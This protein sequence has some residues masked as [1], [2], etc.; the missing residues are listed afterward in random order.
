MRLKA[1][2][3]ERA[4]DEQVHILR[5]KQILVAVEPGG[6]GFYLR[7]EVT[8]LLEYLLGFQ[9]YTRLLSNVG[10]LLMALSRL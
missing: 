2:G 1:P 5:I 6:I 8:W 4:D 9:C 10:K 3:A 7:T